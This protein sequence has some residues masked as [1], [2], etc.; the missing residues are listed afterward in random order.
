MATQTLTFTTTPTAAPSYTKLTI[1][2]ATTTI[3]RTQSVES[4]KLIGRNP[5]PAPSPAKLQRSSSAS[6]MLALV[7]LANLQRLHIC[8][9]EPSSSSGGLDSTPA[10]SAAD[11]DENTA[12]SSDS[13]ECETPDQVSPPYTRPTSPIGYIYDFDS[14]DDDTWDIRKVKYTAGAELAPC[15]ARTG[16]GSAAVAESS[17]ASL[18]SSFSDSEDDE[19]EEE[20]DG[21]MI[22]NKKRSWSPGT[23]AI[24]KVE[25]HW[26]TP[27]TSTA[28][29]SATSSTVTTPLTPVEDDEDGYFN[30]DDDDMVGSELDAGEVWPDEMDSDDF[31]FLH[32][33]PH[34]WIWTPPSDAPST[35]ANPTPNPLPMIHFH[36]VESQVPDQSS[37]TPIQD[38]RF[39]NSLTVPGHRAYNCAEPT[40]TKARLPTPIL[41]VAPMQQLCEGARVEYDDKLGRRA[42]R[43]PDLKEQKEMGLYSVPSVSTTSSSSSSSSSQKKGRGRARSRVRGMADDDDDYDEPQVEEGR[44]RGRSSGRKMTVQSAR[45]FVLSSIREADDGDEEGDEEPFVYD[46]VSGRATRLSRWD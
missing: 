20:D 5:S 18:R 22:S 7:G 41:R 9:S 38:S 6:E 8:A 16:A 34:S 43:V 42:V 46:G 27:T 36:Y 23:P 13:E 37:W 44:G 28:S 15:Y 4:I 26:N 14:E 2:N 33:W 1:P 32:S 11:D 39:G 21:M 19:D 3:P 40:P 35:Y 12:S 24:E 25:Y 31:P 10:A 45:H 17:S 30:D 29:S